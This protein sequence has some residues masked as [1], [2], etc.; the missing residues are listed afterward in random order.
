MKKILLAFVTIASTL[1]LSSCDF[2]AKKINDVVDD[3]EEKIVFDSEGHFRKDRLYHVNA[4]DLSMNYT[5]NASG[6]ATVVNLAEKDTVYECTYK[7]D[8]NIIT[9]TYNDGS[10]SYIDYCD[11]IIA[12]PQ[13]D[14]DYVYHGSYIGILDGVNASGRGTTTIGYHFDICVLQD[15]LPAVFTGDKTS[16]GLVYAIKKNGTIDTKPTKYLR[17]DNFDAS[18]VEDTSNPGQKL[19]NVYAEKSNSSI[20]NGDKTFRAVFNIVAKS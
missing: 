8:K 5:F 20:N 13:V 16:K 9:L 7:A 17:A 18:V 15:D 1:A 19:V 2:L 4:T 10:I 6:S 3:T 14:L 11:D 12:V